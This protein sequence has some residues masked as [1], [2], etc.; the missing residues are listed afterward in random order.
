M[1]FLKRKRILIPLFIVI[2]LFAFNSCATFR[3]SDKKV[4]KEFKK[5]NITP[6]IYREKFEGKTVRY[7]ASKS[8]DSLIPTI[9]FIHG[10]PGSSDN[11][12][13]HL[14]DKEL[15]AKANLI[16]VDRLGYGYSDYGN[17]E[18]SIDK[19][20][21][22]IYTIIQKHGLKNVVLLSWSYGGPIVGKMAVKYPEV[23]HIFM[24]APA[25][26]PDDEKFFG[27]GKLV[28]WKST[29]W[30]FSKAFRVSD[31]E[32]STHVDELTKMENDWK[33]IRIPIHYYHGKKDWIVPY[34][35]MNFIKK[36]ASE[37]LLTAKTFE[38]GNHFIIFKN[39]ELIKEDL[40]EAIK[41]IE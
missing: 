18:T 23:K 39:Y 14:Q 24:I 8:I 13:K 11:F 2:V 34:E 38:K 22:S 31:D 3:K 25:I 1:R 33:N 28:H 7:I 40:L 19:Q 32:K 21:E 41:I 30:I 37:T 5:E 17:S 20:A 36:N 27:I 9:I 4:Y 6:T 16:T 15:S 26:S 10:A 29:R 12:F 35:N